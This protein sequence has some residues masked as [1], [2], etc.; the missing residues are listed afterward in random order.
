ML[1]T[2]IRICAR[3]VILIIDGAFREGF[4]CLSTSVSG[5]VYVSL[6]MSSRL[7][8][9]VSHLRC[10]DSSG[11]V[12]AVDSAKVEGEGTE[13]EKEE[14]YRNLAGA[15]GSSFSIISLHLSPVAVLRQ[16]ILLC[17]DPHHEINQK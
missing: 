7:W 6:N 13:Y 2:N 11:F 15:T 10:D 1:E 16:L 9:F 14:N 17:L 5:K 3:C 12:A 8:P 4:D